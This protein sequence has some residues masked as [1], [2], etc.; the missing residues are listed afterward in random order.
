M[1][2]LD[3]IQHDLEKLL[4]NCSIRQRRL[5]AEVSRSTRHKDKHGKHSDKVNIKKNIYYNKVSRKRNAIKFNVI[6]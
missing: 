3:G 1:T 2:D 5:R 4:S 6:K